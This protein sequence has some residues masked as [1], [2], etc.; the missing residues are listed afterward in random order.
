LA[1]H[2]DAPNLPSTRFRLVL[3]LDELAVTIVALPLST[4]PGSPNN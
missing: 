3:S 4:K 1:G 2:L